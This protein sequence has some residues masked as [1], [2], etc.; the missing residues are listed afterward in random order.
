MRQTPQ[1]FS[2]GNIRLNFNTLK[3]RDITHF[4]HSILGTNVQRAYADNG[5]SHIL[6]CIWRLWR[7]TDCDSVQKEGMS[8][9]PED[10]GRSMQDGK[11][12]YETF[13]EHV[14]ALVQEHRRY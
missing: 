14:K 10:E 13:K 8:T 9:V 6:Y 12:R 5:Q 1:C 4:G 3:V 7:H 11:S 2:L